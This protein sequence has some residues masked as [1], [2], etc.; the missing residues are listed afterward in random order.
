M[1]SFDIFVDKHLIH[2]DLIVVNLPL[3]NDVA[4]YSH[5]LLDS[6]ILNNMTANKAFTSA[7]VCDLSV[8]A[9]TS[10]V[11]TKYDSAGF[12]PAILNAVVDMFAQSSLAWQD[13]VLELSQSVRESSTKMEKASLIT[14]IGAND[15]LIA[16]PLKSFGRIESFTDL[17]TIV[18]EIKESILKLDNA[19]ELSID[20]S[21]QS[22]FS[23]YYE[24]ASMD[25]SIAAT[26]KSLSRLLE[27]RLIESGVIVGAKIEEIDLQRS[28]GKLSTGFAVGAN[29]TL[30]LLFSFEAANTINAS[31]SAKF[32]PQK[33]IDGS[34]SA[35]LHG[36]MD[37]NLR[38]A[39]PLSEID[40]IG[41]LVDIDNM[42]LDD[43]SYVEI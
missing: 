42:T 41:E 11:A 28:F 10:L 17:D 15:A 32:V 31:A 25:S 39:R 26:A 2:G 1:K 40:S 9:S 8:N 3:R 5:I 14:L 12:D 19:D 33:I 18:G 22:V 29:A 24:N 4:A 7:D 13:N 36:S 23:E 35:S 27:S 43:L 16:I 34:S 20:T 37:A 21:L 6:K 38:Y 30:A